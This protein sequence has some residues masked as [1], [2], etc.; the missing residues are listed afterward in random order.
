MRKNI[1]E[2]QNLTKYYG[3]I[4]GV[5]NLSLNLEEGEI[6]G[7]IG[8]NGAGKSTTIRSIMNLI[9]KTS[10]KVLIENK[11]F[12]KNDVEI[13]EKI[14]YLPSEIYLYD[15]LTVKE[16]LDYHESFYKNLTRLSNH[17]LQSGTP[18]PYCSHNKKDIHKRRVELVKR[19]ELDEKKKIEDLSLG[20]LKKLGIILALAHEPKILILDEPTSGL[21]PIMQNVFYDLLKEEKA[22]GDTI[23]YSTHILNEVSK[24]CDRVGIIKDGGLIKVEKVEDLSKKSLTFVTITS[25]ESKEIIKDLRVDIISEDGNTVKFGNNLPHDELIKKLSKYKIDR[26]LIEEATLEDVFLHYYK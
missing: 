8:P 19:L 4:K 9:N 5:E 2:I 13:K 14:G 23:F 1:L 17:R 7:F 26:I 11:E 22:K 25:E 24:I 6:F 12:N 16:M 20:N 18:E 21:D 10:G 3:K 15:D